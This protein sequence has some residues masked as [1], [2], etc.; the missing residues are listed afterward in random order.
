M[1]PT[2]YVPLLTMTSRFTSPLIKT[3]EITGLYYCLAGQKKGNAISVRQAWKR[4]KWI[5]PWP[6]P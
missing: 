3:Q 4:Q 1:L 5:V 2:R 6:N